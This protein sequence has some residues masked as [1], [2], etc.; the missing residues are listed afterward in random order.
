MSLKTSV[1]LSEK[2]RPT[3][4]AEFVG[5]DR[6]VKVFRHLAANPRESAWLLLG[7]S[8][9]GKTTAV[10]AFAAETGAE[11]HEIPSKACDLETIQ[12]ICDMCHY[13][14]FGGG[15]HIILVN[16]AD[17]MSAAAQLALLSKL[18][19]TDPPPST[20][21]FF[22]CNEIRGLEDRFLSRCKLLEIETA[23]MIEPVARFLSSIW[24]REGRSLKRAP[25]FRELFIRCGYNVRSAINEL[26]LEMIAPSSKVEPI[27]SSL[28]SP[29]Y[30]I[31]LERMTPADLRRICQI[32][33]VNVLIDCGPSIFKPRTDYQRA[34]ESAGIT[35]EW[36]RELSRAA[37][38]DEAIAGLK[39]LSRD[40]TVMLADRA[41]EPGESHRHAKIGL[42]LL[43]LGVDCVH[44][45]TDEL[46]KASDLQRA[47]DQRT[48]YAFTP[49]PEGVAA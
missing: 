21:F 32:L 5:I 26:E 45:Y 7:P 10:Q 38:S 46:I 29:I 25:D 47:I 20:I 18:D 48:D 39:K 3:K 9:V 1:Q 30:T 44:V 19:S 15:F 40:R 34:I 24:Q 41:P 43:K 4:I 28:K 49:F 37:L 42:G 17:K 31:G 6:L 14:P 16:E 12:R 27:S 11:L 23:P 36:Q 2:Y 22:T 35:F 33:G 8:G 13:V